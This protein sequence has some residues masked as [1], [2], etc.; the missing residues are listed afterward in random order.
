MLCCGSANKTNDNVANAL[1][2]SIEVELVRLTKFSQEQIA[3][4][5]NSF[6]ALKSKN[7]DRLS[8]KEFRTAIDMGVASYS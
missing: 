7:S 5:H 2:Y 8:K 3:E 4:F 1:D 6:N